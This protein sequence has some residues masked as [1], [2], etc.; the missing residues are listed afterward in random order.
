M[1]HHRTLGELSPIAKHATDKGWTAGYWQNFLYMNPNNL[2]AVNF[3]GNL[4]ADCV[5]N[6]ARFGLEGVQLDDHFG[7]CKNWA[8]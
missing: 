3:L 1:V 6:Y 7:A 5:T 8:H 4:L 2:E